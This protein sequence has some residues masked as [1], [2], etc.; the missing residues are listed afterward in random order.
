MEV[1]TSVS[2]PCRL[3]L[4]SIGSE[5]N[6]GN[7]AGVFRKYSAA[8][9]VRYTPPNKYAQAKYFAKNPDSRRTLPAKLMSITKGHMNRIMPP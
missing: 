4:L 6:A 2:P 9:P 8:V 5:L 7:G 1:I 3:I